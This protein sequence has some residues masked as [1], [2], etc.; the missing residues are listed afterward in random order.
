[1]PPSALLQGD[2]DGKSVLTSSTARLDFLSS[3]L[4]ESFLFL[5]KDR[6]RAM[7]SST[8][9]HASPSRNYF[10]STTSGATQSGSSLPYGAASRDSRA[11]GDKTSSSGLPPSPA[12]GSGGGRSGS[13]GKP[14]GSTSAGGQGGAVTGI[15]YWGATAGGILAAF[16]PSVLT[17]SPAVSQ[18]QEG[19][20]RTS[21]EG[22]DGWISADMEEDARANDINWNAD[23]SAMLSS[24]VLPGGGRGRENGGDD[25]EGILKL[26]D[27]IDRLSK[28]FREDASCAL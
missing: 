11:G 6:D 26:L 8:V 18:R 14:Y 20:R 2:G 16:A 10:P 23:V 22:D 3:S 13:D 1:M 21:V 19:Q 27:T 9:L 25:A 28:W 5:S 4:G 15:A 17:T 7:A 24:S 12:Y